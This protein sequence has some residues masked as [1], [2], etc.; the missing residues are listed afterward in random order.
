MRV[1][2]AL[3][4][5]GLVAAAAPTWGQVRGGRDRPGPPEPGPSVAPGPDLIALLLPPDPSAATLAQQLNLQLI[6]EYGLFLLSA[7]LAHYRIPDSRPLSIVLAAFGQRGITADGN[8]AYLQPQADPLVSRQYAIPLVGAER[9]H[10]A[11]RGRQIRVAVVDSGVETAHEDLREA[12]VIRESFIEPSFQMSA[13]AHGT[14]VAGLIGARAN[15]MGIVG[16]A[17][18]ASIIALQVCTPRQPGVFEATCTALRVARGVDAAAKH[19]AQVLNMSV[20]GPSNRVLARV[21]QEVLTQG[22]IVVA[23]SGNN[24]PGGLPLYPAALAGVIAVAAT[25]H[26]DQIY[27]RSN[28]G[29]HVAVLAPGVDLMTTLPGGRY[30]FV[31]GTSFASAYVSGVVALLLDA[32]G[33][34]SRQ[35][36]VNALKAGA[37]S[38]GPLSLGRVDVCRALA[39][40][41]KPEACR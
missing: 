21:V 16:M 38:T 15:G 36:I 2:V 35:E 24:G 29:A 13:D 27:E 5:L 4:L 9:A 1:A 22:L 37:V 28:L 26:R 20:G 17:P 3:L 18:E 8:T 6:A 19:K 10:A 25:D 32:A 31:T 14:A 40:L 33:S 30:A 39:H 23:A 11:I 34:R 7:R 41:G 12:I